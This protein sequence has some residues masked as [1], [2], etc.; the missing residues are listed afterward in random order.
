ML[1]YAERN[2]NFQGFFLLSFVLKVLK[3]RINLSCPL[4]SNFSFFPHIIQNHFINEAP[5][6]MRRAGTCIQAPL[7]RPC[8]SVV[9]YSSQ[10]SLLEFTGFY[11]KKS[12][13]N[14]STKKSSSKIIKF[15]I[16]IIILINY[17]CSVM[18][19]DMEN[20]WI[21]M[22]AT[23]SSLTSRLVFPRSQQPVYI[24]AGLLTLVV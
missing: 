3:K 20:I 13:A 19:K 24:C 9:I 5:Y 15:K 21:F 7:V 2:T 4:I 22:N 11:Q 17:F 10:V 18:R 14:K 8:N 16:F 6:A 1:V 12:S 23:I